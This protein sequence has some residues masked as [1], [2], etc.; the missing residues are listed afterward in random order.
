MKDS[1]HEQFSAGP[2]TSM[3]DDYEEEN[4]EKSDSKK[5]DEEASSNPKPRTGKRM[6]GF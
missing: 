4:D 5:A 6:Y 2:V 1:R 3:D